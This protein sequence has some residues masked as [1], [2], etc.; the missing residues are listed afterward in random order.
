VLR[1]R[2][3]EGA[4]L[5]ILISPFQNYDEAWGNSHPTA[6]ILFHD[7]AR[8]NSE[9]ENMMSAG[10]G[11]SPAEGRLARILAESKTLTQAAAEVGVSVNTANT[12]LA[13]IFARTGFSR[14]VDLVAEIRA[15][16][17]LHIVTR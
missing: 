9:P 13:S 4:V 16:P 10:Y 17:L 7:P 1:L 15:N 5:P 3:I 6:A 14:Q 8:Q 12:Q 2:G 11:L